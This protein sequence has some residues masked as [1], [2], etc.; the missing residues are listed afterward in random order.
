MSCERPAACPLS[1]RLRRE[2][3]ARAVHMLLD[4]RDGR[5][6]SP[7]QPAGGIQ[8][9]HVPMECG[10]HPEG[11]LVADL[12]AVHLGAE[13]RAPFAAKA[14][15]HLIIDRPPAAAEIRSQIL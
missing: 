15:Q 14:P 13:S 8:R 3:R 12:L 7:V 1:E 4:K 6:V 10:L 11:V 9:T 2:D 5:I